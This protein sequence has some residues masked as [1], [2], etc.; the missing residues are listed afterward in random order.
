MLYDTIIIGS[1]MAGYSAGLYSGRFNLKTAIM[2][3]NEPGGATINAWIVENYPGAPNIKGYEL[4]SKIESQARDFGAVIF[5]EEVKAIEKHANTFLIKSSENIYE[6]K[7]VIIATGMNHRK[8]NLAN[9]ERLVGKGVCY[10]ATCDGPLYKD[11]KIIVVGGGDAGVKSALLLKQFTDD[12]TVITNE[13]HVRAEPINLKRFKDAKIPVIYNNTI[14]ELIEENDKLVKIKLSQPYQDKDILEVDGLFVEIGGIPNT[15]L[16]K[17]VGV[18]LDTRGF[19]VVDCFMATNIKG[20]FAAG[21]ITNLFGDFK[22]MITAAASG[23]LA[24]YSVY[25]YLK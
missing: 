19:I 24:A 6:A 22:Q 3:G 23:A 9:E 18:K 13:P 1:G 10:C 15:D 2:T 4:I 25:K 17:S 5:N 7:A 14:D 21:D 8:L 11:K 20:I 16:A 12:I